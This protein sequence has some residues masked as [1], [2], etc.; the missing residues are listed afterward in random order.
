MKRCSLGMQHDHR[1]ANHEDNSDI[2]KCWHTGFYKGHAT[3]GKL[4]GLPANI[5]V[6][7]ES[8]VVIQQL[9]A[10]F[11]VLALS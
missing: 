6:Q 2:M 5:L 9:Q 7:E 11:Q 8:E 3:H 4:P 1:Q 10:H